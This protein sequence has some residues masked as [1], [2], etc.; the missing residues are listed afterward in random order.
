MLKNSIRYIILMC[1]TM[2]GFSVLGYAP[3]SANSDAACQSIFEKAVR[4][5]KSGPLSVY[6]LADKKL[7]IELAKE[8]FEKD[9]IFTSYVER[10]VVP[11]VGQYA[12][13]KLIS[14]RL[15]GEKVDLIE[16]DS[17]EYFDTKSAI[18]RTRLLTMSDSLLGSLSLHKCK[19][20]EVKYAYL[21]RDAL[22][23]LSSGFLGDVSRG[24]AGISGW[25]S[26][27]ENVDFITEHN[28]SGVNQRGDN[29][30]YTIRVRHILLNKPKEP[31]TPRPADPRVGFFTAYRKN[32]SEFDQSVQDAFIHRWRLEKKNAEAQL[33]EPVKPIVFWI[34]NTTPKKFR[35]YIK[36][37]VLAWNE[38]FEAAGFVNAVEVYEQPDDATWEAGDVSKNVIRWYTS[39][40]GLVFLGF[41]PAIYDPV[42]GEILGADIMLNFGGIGSYLDDWSRLSGETP[43]VKEKENSFEFGENRAQSKLSNA[44]KISNTI[45]HNKEL[46]SSDL[47]DAYLL[48]SLITDR[49]KNKTLPISADELEKIRSLTST[50]SVNNPEHKATLKGKKSA[51][52]QNKEDL[53]ERMVREV[54]IQLTMH[55]VGHALGLTHNFRGSNWRSMEEIFDR[56]KTNGMISASVMDYLPINFSPIGTAQGDFANTRLG[57]YDIWAIQY[58]YSSEFNDA[59]RRELLSRSSKSEYAFA[60]NNLR[61]INPYILQEDLTDTP[62]EYAKTRFQFALD[63]S[64]LAVSHKSFSTYSQYLSLFRELSGQVNLAIYAIIAQVTPMTTGA[65]QVDNNALEYFPAVSVYSKSKQKNALLA[66]QELVFENDPLSLSEEFKSRLGSSFFMYDQVRIQSK[67]LVIS[68]LMNE[69]SLYLRHQAMQQ[70]SEYGPTEMLFDLK[71]AVFGSDLQ[72]F[73][74]PSQSRR[75]QQIIFAGYLDELIVTDSDSTGMRRSPYFDHRSSIVSAAARPVRAAILRELLI[76]TPWASQEVRAHREELREILK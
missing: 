53:A 14:F 32:L 51:P 4:S 39:N 48:A 1:G 41:A 6:E 34:E 66:L 50:Q 63:V 35:P 57:P 68:E 74:N 19:S 29:A 13:P 75:D 55:E 25:Y 9:F 61:S 15:N 30:N 33:S 16:K 8:D 76:P 46:F 10:G 42:T 44:H 52:D 3:A 62:L 54:I 17:V 11:Y 27:A 67:T 60:E 31:F 23:K 40:Q 38:A 71:D 69:R 70:G 36:Q 72:P 58:G 18:S 49:Q 12:E 2:L 28:L 5:E 45:F 59:K 64:E 21:T 65:M 47:Q 73:V 43:A 56:E 20:E 24:S 26:Y 37:G 22:S 7:V